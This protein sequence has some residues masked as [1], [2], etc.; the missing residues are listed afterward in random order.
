M[1]GAS[2]SG[3]TDGSGGEATGGSATGGGAGD[4][5]AQ[6]C[7]LAK[8]TYCQGDEIWRRPLDEACS[9]PSEF[10]EACAYGCSISTLYQFAYC[11]DPPSG[12]AGGMGGGGGLGGS[13]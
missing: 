8:E 5:E 12:G 7:C 1:G 3:G 2:G 9:Q 13:P 6:N 10:R 4:C 11:E